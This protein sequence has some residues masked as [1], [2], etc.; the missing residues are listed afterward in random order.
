MMVIAS[1]TPA[2]YATPQGPIRS[3]TVQQERVVDAIR[4]GKTYA[5]IGMELGIGRETVK[6]HVAAIM[7]VL[8]NPDQLEPRD[9]IFLWSWW[10]AWT[11]ALEVREAIMQRMEDEARERA[12]NG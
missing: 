7:N 12:T 5:E 4:R 10:R 11:G 1:T 3:L 6:G 2:T 9:C 8:P